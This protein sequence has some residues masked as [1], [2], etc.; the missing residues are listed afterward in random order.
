MTQPTKS[1][2]QLADR[3][4]NPMVSNRGAAVTAAA[5]AT[6]VNPTAPT[7]IPA[8]A[9]GSAITIT[10][11]DA[12]DLTTTSAALAVLE[13]EVATYETAI[14]AL[15]VDV[16]LIRVALNALI[17]RVEAHGLIADN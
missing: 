6:A 9:T 7:D 1:E 17:E 5:S 16:D 8:I 14:S 13:N 3:N 4:D 12:A 10:T 2:S 15:I 11:N